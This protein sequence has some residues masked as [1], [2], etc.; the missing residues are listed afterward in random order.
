MLMVNPRTWW[1]SLKHRQYVFS[2]TD[3]SGYK[4][5]SQIVS[6]QLNE[7]QCNQQTYI[8]DC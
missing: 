8:F 3:N 5:I 4:N 6:K 2:Y 1:L 7:K